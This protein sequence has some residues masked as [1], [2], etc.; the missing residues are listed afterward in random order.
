[1]RQAALAVEEMGADVLYTWD[2]FFPIDGDQG[3]AHFECWTLLAAWAEATSRILL[4]P[5]V[6]CVSYRNADLLADMARTLDH[7][8]NGRVVL[9]LGAGWRKEE[10]EAYGYDFGTPRERLQ[11]LE[12]AVER[13]K[14]RLCQLNPPAVGSIPILIGGTGSQRTLPL[15][16]KYADVWHAMFPSSPSELAPRLQRFRKCQAHADRKDA[17]CRIAI[18]V[19]TAQARMVLHRYA[20]AYARLGVTQFTVGVSGPQFDTGPVDEWLRWRDS[21]TS[22]TTP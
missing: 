5:L 16:A 18:G 20:D 11:V 3:G 6:S 14:R 1:M 15:A 22:R 7:V 9:G 21:S 12:G 19:K 2:H 10:Y 17:S 8:S 4:G 13:I